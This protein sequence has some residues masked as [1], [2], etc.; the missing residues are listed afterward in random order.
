MWKEN[1][2]KILIDNYSNLG[3]KKCSQLL[4]KSEKSILMK[5]HRLL[6]KLNKDIKGKIIKNS[7]NYKENLN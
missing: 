7:R 5:A 1:E 2:V 3:A 4:N 6:L